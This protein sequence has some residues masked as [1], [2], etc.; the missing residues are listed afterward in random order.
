M[1][2]LTRYQGFWPHLATVA[3]SPIWLFEDVIYT[4]QQSPF[5]TIGQQLTFEH[6][7]FGRLCRISKMKSCCLPFAHPQKCIVNFH[8]FM[9]KV[10]CLTVLLFYNQFCIL[11]LFQQHKFSYNY[12]SYL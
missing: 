6:K 8:N 1:L 9:R 2:I 3:I 7:H 10:S 11:N 12:C 4:V 5:Y